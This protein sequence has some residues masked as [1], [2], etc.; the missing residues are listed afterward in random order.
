MG[1][2]RIL[3][4]SP[5]P[6]LLPHP[7]R[8]TRAGHPSRRHHAQIATTLQAIGRRQVKQGNP[9]G[10]AQK[11]SCVSSRSSQIQVAWPV[12]GGR[13][14]HHFTFVKS[15]FGFFKRIFIINCE[16]VECQYIFNLICLASIG[17]FYAKLGRATQSNS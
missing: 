10:Q 14:S 9:S 3:T 16:F 2:T 17:I 1:A 13:A 12:W 5:S 7:P 6:S 4:R 11:R 15:T 8:L